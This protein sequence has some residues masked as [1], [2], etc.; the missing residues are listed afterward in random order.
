MNSVINKSSRVCALIPGEREC[1][2]AQ[3][4]VGVAEYVNTRILLLKAYSYFTA[5]KMSNEWV[6]FASNSAKY[7]I[8]IET[9]F[10]PKWL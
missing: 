6:F 10:K 5:E 1:T 4:H 8:E 9:F 7:W 3:E 2:T